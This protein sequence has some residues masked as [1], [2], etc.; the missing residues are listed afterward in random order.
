MKNSRINQL[1]LM[2]LEEDVTNEDVSTNAIIPEDKWGSV[3][4]ICKEMELLQV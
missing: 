3:Q 2:A 1:I 4:L